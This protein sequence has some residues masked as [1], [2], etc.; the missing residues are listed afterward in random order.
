VEELGMVE[1]T[2]N[3][4]TWE[5]EAGGLVVQDQLGLHNHSK[6]KIPKIVIAITMV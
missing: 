5:A 4:S 1:H 3:P 2:C 6:N